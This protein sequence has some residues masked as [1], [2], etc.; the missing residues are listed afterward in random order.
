MSKQLN[1]ELKKLRKEFNIL[2]G[3]KLLP[4]FLKKDFQDS[5][6]RETILQNRK[7][8][9]MA[10]N[11]TIFIGCH[12]HYRNKCIEC[13]LEII[14]Q[15][16]HDNNWGLSGEQL[17]K[18]NE[19]FNT[20]I[21]LKK[22]HAIILSNSQIANF[23]LIDIFCKNGYK[24]RDGTP[25]KSDYTERV[26]RNKTNIIIDNKSLIIWDKTLRTFAIDRLDDNGENSSYHLTDILDYSEEDI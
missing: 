26:I 22:P 19:K 17:I 5:V 12:S 21:D 16:Q 7:Y 6:I 14:C 23:S 2:I 24:W 9:E 4:E 11:N 25:C 15:E 8:R 18:I 13:P 1:N 10:T 3:E 20:L